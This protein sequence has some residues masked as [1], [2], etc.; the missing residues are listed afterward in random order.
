MTCPFFRTSMFCS[1]LHWKNHMN[2]AKPFLNIVLLLLFSLVFPICISFE[3]IT[4]N[5]PLKDGQILV[6]Y[7]KPLRLGF[8]PLKIPIAAMLGF[9]ITKLLNKLLCGLQ[10]ETILFMISPGSSPSTVKETLY[11]TLKTNPFPFGPLM[12]LLQP[13]Q[14]TIPWLSSQK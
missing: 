14:Q 6:S 7:Q 13:H 4:Q 1:T 3:T 10:I 12:F 8:S 9:G 2:P 5:H 11:S